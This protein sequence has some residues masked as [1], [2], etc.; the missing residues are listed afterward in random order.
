MADSRYRIIVHANG[1]YEVLG[2]VP[3]IRRY[4]AKTIFGEPVEWDAVG[5]EGY[6]I[7]IEGSY[8][9]C[10]CGQSK[11]KPFCDKTHQQITFI[12]ELNADRRQSVERRRSFKGRIL[13]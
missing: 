4:A 5:V 3:L 1:P 12:G 11:N 7:P 13:S 2:G 10:R 8:E 6:D 9:L